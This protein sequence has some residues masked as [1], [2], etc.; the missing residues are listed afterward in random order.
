MLWRSSVVDWRNLEYSDA[1]LDS[2]EALPMTR[3]LDVRLVEAAGVRMRFVSPPYP[4]P[5]SSCT[6]R[7]DSD[8]FKAV[9]LGMSQKH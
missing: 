4:C 8:R 9:N 3:T 5:A 6:P 2:S 1:V 7:Y